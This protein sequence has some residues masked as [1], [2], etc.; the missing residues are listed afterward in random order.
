[1][2]LSASRRTDIPAFYADWFFKRISE[3]YVCVR[4]P[5]NVHQVSSI[6]LSPEVVDCIVFWTKNPAP[7][8]PRLG[9]LQ[10]YDY[11]FQYTVNAYGKDVEPC[12]PPLEERLRTFRELSAR[13]GKERVIWRYDP[14]MF[15]DRYTPEFH[16]EQFTRIAEELNGYTEKCVFSFVDVYPTKNL[17]NLRQLR[18][19]TVSDDAMDL[20]LG[21]MADKAKEYGLTLAT[22]AEKVDLARFGIAHNSCI[23]RELIERIVGCPL[24]TAPDGQRE[25]CQ[26][27]KCDD[28]GAYDTCTHFCA[29]CYANFR[30]DIVKKKS[31]TYDVDSP[32]L[33]DAIDPTEDKV[34]QRPVKSM[35]QP[36][37][38]QLKLF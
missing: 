20:L 28:I 21:G 4:N 37:D 9:E 38:L 30:H 35:K 22:C 11:Y 1:M 5:M 7:M 31:E 23:D 27:I 12:V 26:C 34:T 24:K 18:Q 19:M 10:K 3:G 16:L 33:C 15:T 36:P 17:K 14:I 32:L 13:I 6:S 25:F 8:L 29:Y 2:I